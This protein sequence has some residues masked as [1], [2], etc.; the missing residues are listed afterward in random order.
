LSWWRAAAWAFGAVVLFAAGALALQLVRGLHYDTSLLALLPKDAQRP[1]VSLAVDRMADA[2][3]RQTV[4]L[5]GA[6]D[7]AV[8]ARAADAAAKA[9]EGQEG[10]DRVTARIE[11]DVVGLARDFYLPYRYQLLTPAQRARLEGT[12]DQA[13]IA[14]ALRALYS[15]VAPPRLASLEADPLNLFTEALFDRAGQSALHPEAGHLVVEEGGR[16]FVAVLAELSHG[17]LSM[18]A[19][20]GVTRAFDQA[21][22]AAQRAGASQVLRAG[23]VFHSAEAARQ[24]EHEMSTIGLGSLLGVVL[25]ILWAFRSF[26][27]LGLILLPIAVG[28]VTALGLSQLLFPRL[29]LLTFVF[30]T[31]IIGVAVD[32]GIL[33]LSGRVADGPWDA[34]QRR[35]A[36]L[37]SVGTALGTS[38]LAYAALALMPFPI[39]RQMGVFTMIGLCAAWLTAVLWLPPLSR[40][41][42]PLSGGALPGLLRRARD[43]WPRVGES[44]ALTVM[45]AVLVL[46]ALAGVVRIHANDDVHGLYASS[47][48]L[49]KEQADVERL[50]RLPSAGQFFLLTARDEEALLQR[51]EALAGELELLQAKGTLGGFQAVSRFVPSARSQRADQ[52]LAWRRLFGPDGVAPRL[53]QKLGSPETAAVARAQAQARA[54]QP[55]LTVGTWL[56]SPLSLPF[57]TLWLGQTPEGFASLVTVS[58]ASGD[59][60]QVALAGIAAHLQGVEYVDHLRNVSSLL[61][62]FRVQITW[63]L[64]VGYAVVSLLLIWRY[65]KEAWRALVPA[66][67]GCLFT[68]GALGW[69]RVDFNLFCVFGLLLSLDMG[70]D[71]GVYMQE[72]GAG[73]FRVSVLSASLAAITTLLSF[74]LLALS[75]TPALR[76]FGLT[77]LLAIGGSWLLAPCFQKRVET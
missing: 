10:V 47:G 20:R 8:A 2:G 33:F 44:R 76:G 52:A 14:G 48:T 9:L 70:V 49:V 72:R 16:T 60:A 51:E 41:L 21:V 64:A 66:L 25:L 69:M 55:P 35:R 73:D 12:P 40:K 28:S 53:F 45:L 32:Y 31:S 67:L 5:V 65:R 17:G 68:A 6:A 36:I 42:P 56:Q 24:A 23:F 50:M 61:T 7:P 77:V 43:G 29:H 39:L 37:P 26:K 59:A 38:L 46:A 30:G 57:R 27:P 3:S 58:G 22:A 19:Q 34:L 1:L 62:R 15:P 18:G 13:L 74:G 4:L 71:Y 54:T 75:H 11:G 63:L